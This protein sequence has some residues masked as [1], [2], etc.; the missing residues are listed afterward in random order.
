MLSST[1]KRYQ[2]DPVKNQ[3]WSSKNPGEIFDKLKTRD[4]NATSMSTCDFHTL[5]S[6]LP[7]NLIQE[8]S[9]DLIERTL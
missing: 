1:V 2:R 6:S 5:Y 9:I 3:F 7:H 8:K 4:F